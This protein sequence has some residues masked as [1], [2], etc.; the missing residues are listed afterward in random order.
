MALRVI[1]NTLHQPDIYTGP[2]RQIDVEQCWQS[3]LNNPLLNKLYKDSICYTERWY[4]ETRRLIN[5]ELWYH[6]LLISLLL[7]E[8]L[9]LDLIKSTIIDG[10][11]MRSMI[12]D[13]RYPEFQMSA[14]VNLKKLT[15]WCAFFVSLP[16]S[17]ETLVALNGQSPD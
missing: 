2:H 3:H 12:N 17:H 8:K 15:R 16:D 14:S 11:N 9:K 13:P 4:L 10:V 5:E 6:P 7:D 1:K